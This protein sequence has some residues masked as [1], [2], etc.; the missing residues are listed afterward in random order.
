[1][2]PRS[3]ALTVAPERHVQRQTLFSSE[4]PAAA[5]TASSSIESSAAPVMPSMAPIAG[6]DDVLQIGRC[7][8]AMRAGE[9]T[10]K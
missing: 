7:A 4:A 6:S 3:S 8:L 5:T 10:R 1:M 9:G 2:T